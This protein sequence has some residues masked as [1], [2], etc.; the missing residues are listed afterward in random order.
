MYGIDDKEDSPW[1]P[2]EDEITDALQMIAQEQHQSIDA[3]AQDA[4]R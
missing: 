4:R 3:Y 1:P 2:N